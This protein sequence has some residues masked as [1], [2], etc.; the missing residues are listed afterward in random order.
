MTYSNLVN[1]A[2]QFAIDAHQHVNQTYNGLPYD[3]HLKMAARVAERYVEGYS[4]EGSEFRNNLRAAVWLHDTLEDCHHL[5]YNDLN[6]RFGKDIAELVFAVTDKKG[7]NRKERKDFQSIR[8]IKGATFVKLCDRIANV[9]A[10][11]ILG[12]TMTEKYRQEQSELN[13]ELYPK[14]SD[15]V[16]ERMFY[17]LEHLLQETNAVY[18]HFKPKF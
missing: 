5:S 10:G 6:K 15:E 13:F 7:R 3:F 12:G 17:D 16:L 9:E 11:I 8:D 2:R 4:A 1:E 14:N 18:Q